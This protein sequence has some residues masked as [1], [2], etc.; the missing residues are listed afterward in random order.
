MENLAARALLA[1]GDLAYSW[2]LKDDTVCWLGCSDNVLGEIGIEDIQSGEALGSR[3]N[4]EDINHRLE[5][6]NRH[7]SDNAVYD[8][9]YRVRRAD[10]EFIW[11][12]DRG[13]VSMDEQGKLKCML[14]TLR[15]VNHRKKQENF[16]EQRVNYD[17]LTGHLNKARL[18]E[19]LQTTLAYNERYNIDYRSVQD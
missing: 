13:S 3:I 2:D 5:V 4:P 18:R 7:L 9:E 16:L 12:H 1:A 10:G 11:V 19:S 8:C 6:L 14:G 15:I 17:E